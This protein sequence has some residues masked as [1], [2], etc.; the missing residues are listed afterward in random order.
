ML[1]LMCATFVAA[2]SAQV[3]PAL[4]KTHPHL[5]AYKNVDFNAKRYTL[6]ATHPEQIHI[7]YAGQSAEGY[8]TGINA[9]WVYKEKDGCVLEYGTDSAMHNESVT[10]HSGRYL[11]EGSYH[12][13]VDVL[14]LVPA[15]LYHY[16]VKCGSAASANFT[17]TSAANGKDLGR[18]FNI[19]LFGDM[20]YLGSAER[21][22]ILDVGGLKKHWSA[23]P[24]RET[25]QRFFE[26]GETDMMWIV[27]DIGYADDAFAHDV[28][29]GL[30]EKCYDGFMN[31]FQNIT[32]SIPFHVSPGNHESECHSAECVI[33]RFLG[34]YLGNFSAY[35]NRFHMPSPSSG[36]V[37]NMWYSWNTGPVHFVSLNTETDFEG[38]GE[39]HSG[40][41]CTGFYV[42]H[43]NA[44]RGN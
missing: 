34:E 13:N 36:G 44:K 18:P 10:P 20:G 39:G 6:R 12:W 27:G 33:D 29:G 30:Y 16:R 15:T 35:T 11:D 24:T 25:Q 21:P 17:F 22:M 9:A 4:L 26:A 32:A 14:D 43:A 41:Y 23:V 38:A 19:N 2:A 8:P 42:L 40:W 28:V 7:A 31:W 5:A 1:K 3:T 37:A